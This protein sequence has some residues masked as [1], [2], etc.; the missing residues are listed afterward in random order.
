MEPGNAVV[1][2]LIA[3]RGVEVPVATVIGKVPV[4]A[5]TIVAAPSSFVLS[6]ALIDPADPDVAALIVR[7]GAAPPDE[8]NGSDA[9]TPVTVPPPPPPTDAQT[10]PLV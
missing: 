9:V 8:T 5:E 2:A 3:I 1:A 7:L 4:T 10:L 6:A